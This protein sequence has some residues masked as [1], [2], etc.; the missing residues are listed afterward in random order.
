MQFRENC[1]AFIDRATRQ[2]WLAAVQLYEVVQLVHH[3]F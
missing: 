2:T 3:A 1:S